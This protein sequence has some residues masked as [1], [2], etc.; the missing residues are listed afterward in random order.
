MRKLLLFSSVALLAGALPIFAMSQ[1]EDPDTMRTR[2]A[3]LLKDGNHAEALELYK[4]LALQRDNVE[5]VADDLE[6]A[7]QCLNRLGLVSEID[8]FAERVVAVHDQNWRVHVRWATLL[9]DNTVS[10]SGYIIAGEFIRGPHR[11]GGV[12]ANAASRDRV[13]TL[14][15]LLRALTL[16][17]ADQ[18]A[19]T[20][21]RSDVFMLLAE[22]VGESRLNESWTLQQLTDI[23]ELPEVSPGGF[24]PFQYGRSFQSASRGA[25]VTEDGEPV[26]HQLPESWDASTSDGQRWRWALQQAAAADATRLSEVDL[27]WAEFLQSQFG[28]ATDVIAEPVLRTGGSEADS[29]VAT[30]NAHLLPDTDTIARLATGV[31]RL[32]LPDEF[33][34]ISVLNRIVQRDDKSAFE[35][36]R[37][38]AQVRMNRHQ[39]PRAAETLRQQIEVLDREAPGE[40]D[41]QRA[42]DAI[43]PVQQRKSITQQI[44]QIEN[45]WVQFLSRSVQV[46]GQGTTVDIRYRNGESV[47]FTARPIRI[48]LLLQDLRTYLA[49]RPAKPDRARLQIDDIGYRLVNDDKQRYLDEEVANWTLSLD[50]PEGHFD[51]VQTVSTPLQQAG[52]YWLTAKMEDGNEARIVLWVADTSITRKR[53]ERGTMY[54]VA[55]ARSGAPIADVQLEFF[56]WRQERV[57]RTRDFRTDI[58][59]F[60]EQ[61]SADGLCTP[62][63]S[64][65]DPKYQW[66]TI[67][68]TAD[69]RLAFDGFN[70]IW[71][72]KE[73]NPLSFGPV[74]V[75]SITDRPV[76][77]P[78]HTVKFRMWVRRPR[79]DADN[80]IYAGQQFIVEVR[81]PKGDI[82]Q[83]TSVTSD[84]WGGIDGEFAIDADATLGQYVLRVCQPLKDR[85]DNRSQ[86]GVGRFRVEEYRKPEFKVNIAA[87]EKP[88]QLGEAFTATINAE[89]YFGAPVADGK[90]HYKVER[91]D[92]DE[93]WYPVAAWDWLYGPGYWW[94]AP[95]YDWYPG[96]NRWGCVAPIPPWRGWRADPPEIVAEG[97][98]ELRPDGTFQ[99]NV[100]TSS[101]LQTFSD[102][103]HSYTITAEV[104]D[105]SR[106]TITGTGSV[107]VAR[108][109]FRVFTWTDRGHYETGDTV[110]VGVQA[111]TPD[112]KGIAGDCRITLSS[113][114]YDEDL[115]VETALESWN[116]KTDE[117]GQTTLQLVVPQ[118]GQFR[119]S[120]DVTDDAGRTQQGGYV[121][122]VRGPDEDGADYRF[123]ALELVTD[124]REYQPGD[125]VQLQ[126][127]TDQPNSTVLLFLRPANGLCPDPQV[128][129]ISGKSVTVPVRV[130]VSDMPNFFIEAVTIADGQLHNVM[131]EVVVPPE[132][133]VANV[134]VLPSAER[135]RPGE[136]AS[137]QLKVT[138]HAGQPVAGNVVL[139]VY[140]A[141]LEYIAAADLPEIR[142]FFWNMRRQH[143]PA[144]VCTLSRMTG[145]T[146]L[147]KETLMRPLAGGDPLMVATG[148]FGAGAA[149][150]NMFMA[151]GMAAD[152]ALP[153]P[154]GEMGGGAA[155]KLSETDEAAPQLRSTF[156][157]TAF[158]LGNGTSNSDGML[159]VEFPLPDNLTTWKVKAWSLSDGTRVG[160]GESEIVCS[161]DLIIRPQTPRFFTETDRITISAVVHNYLDSSKSTRVLLEAEGGQLLLPSDAE[162]VLQIPAGGEAR[163]DWNVEVVASGTVKL[164]MAALTDTESDATEFTV[165][166]QVHGIL[167][168]ESE[169][170]V[171]EASQESATVQVSVPADRIEEQSRLEIRF[172][173]T[174]AGAMVDALPYL[175]DY[176]YGCT[177]QTL[178]RFLPA[179][180]TRRTLQQMGINL[181]DVQQKRTNLNAQELGDPAKRAAQWKQYNRNPVFDEREMNRII[182]DGV[183]ALTEMQLTDGGWGWFSG[184]GESSSAHLTAQVVHGLTVAKQNGV[185]VLDDVLARG[186]EWLKRHQTT[187]VRELK[188]GDWRQKHPD[189]LE[190][191]DRKYR[192]SASNLDAF[193]LWVLSEHDAV[194]PQMADYLYRDRDRLSLY[195]KGLTGIVMHSMQRFEQRDMLLRNIEQVLVQ[196]DENQTAWLR[197]DASNWWYWYGSEYEA[198]AT[199]LKLLLLVRPDDTTAPRLV[200]YLLNNRKNGTY[201]NSTRDTAMVVEAMAMYIRET[202]EDRPDMTVEI[203]L[204]G[205]LQKRVRITA[206]NLFSFDN[207][208]LLE[209]DTVKS[210]NHQIEIRRTGT[211]PVYFNAYLTNFTKEQHIT[212]AGLE[213][214]VQ[215]NYFRL[216]RDDAEVAVAGDR[217][218][219]IQT[220]TERYKRVPV[221]NLDA[222]TSGDLIEV[223]LIIESKNDYEYL[224]LEDHKP[225][226]FEPDDQRSG[227]IFEGLRAYRELRDDR[228]SFFLTNLARGR[229]SLKYRI[230]A[231]APSD[232]VAALPAQISGMYAPELAGNSDEIKLRVSDR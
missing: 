200:K 203:L 75:Y 119:I 120:V 122:F 177:E 13:R 143:H 157:D 228:V 172:S 82:V 112:G 12:Y 104:V 231:E 149:G 160:S 24:G 137:V 59:R 229:H 144:T 211:G 94:F 83:E 152:A 223:E 196:D 106:R 99:I 43:T 3:R 118:S 88:V 40:A 58:S 84:Q 44:E 14:Q 96:W 121:F 26:F 51:A 31:K 195:A 148:S 9:H 215:R 162:R 11:G 201:W 60:A 217:G 159:Q 109:P 225:S 45:N 224:L 10:P 18:Q 158:W 199:Y 69:G 154:A 216:E 2:A 16:I 127:N 15:A 38:L 90:V 80:A 150:G 187:A 101:A 126:I 37:R 191:R 169:S 30:W 114:R 62:D 179:V 178:N 183:Q 66:L 132:Q 67:A 116:L 167:K 214:K 41:K 170:G 61:T 206:D 207:V 202:G 192:N 78:G 42:P 50:A 56:G 102:S 190:G 77:R 52:A 186:V 70:R 194:D 7:V 227:Y 22:S 125:T 20:R 182:K 147:P 27:V 110:S 213:V 220:Q 74:K 86:F 93:H 107:I 32:T 97:D 164:R 54:Y 134:E 17:D 232:Q 142:A 105:Q 23:T 28:V 129:R 63:Q 21:E 139:S 48:D 181:Q 153:A 108:E 53:V 92:R 8:E 218:Q 36:L 46:A 135:Y 161:K 34:H 76:Y 171:L 185:P 98:A 68:Q 151:R 180:L 100:D 189:K 72:P 166:V 168:T 89:Y 133:R 87:P 145:P 198:M 197:T 85:P 193:V 146:Y 35:A 230:R 136:Q 25:P 29:D 176:P 226:G 130:T 184:Y 221:R 95:E 165:P 65:L 1:Q 81:N 5:Q 47:A 188:E 222:V 210:G 115:P 128:V 140:D 123:N 4:S 138:D 33:N 219:V 113:V 79:F 55:D 174:L 39:Y 71:A 209:G 212:A 103:D 204:D 73:I 175:I 49:T 173:P 57:G 205:R 131:R 19:T 141:S 117:S 156:A 6:Q 111:R 124:Q 208:V 91:S 163:V 64:Q 155:M